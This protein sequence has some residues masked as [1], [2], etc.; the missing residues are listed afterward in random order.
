MSEADINAV[1]VSTSASTV[2]YGGESEMDKERSRIAILCWE[3]GQVPRGLVQLETL[4]G[5]STNPKSYPFPVRFNRIKGANI[6][7]VLEDPSNEV[8]KNMIVESKKMISEGI[9]AITTS[10]GF[11]AIFQEELASALDVPVFTSSLLQV[12]MVHKML[13]LEKSIAVITA[14]KSALKVEHLRAVGITDDIRLNILGMENSPEWNKIF[15][16]PDDDVDLNVIACEVIGTAKEAVSMDK[17]IGVFVLECTD[18]PPFADQIKKELH[19]PVFDFITM[20][21][22]VAR[23]IGV[24]KPYYNN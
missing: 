13:G 20:M 18:L 4:Q 21:E 5:N 23:S 16:A 9:E 11:N 1:E 19:L 2:P 8:L 7:T 10:C 3:A 12:P 17:D 22:Y 24:V 6:H 14:K 15:T